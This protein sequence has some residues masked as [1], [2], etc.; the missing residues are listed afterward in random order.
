MADSSFATDVTAVSGLLDRLASGVNAVNTA[1]T[2]AVTAIGGGPAVTPS[3]TQDDASSSFM[4]LLGLGV[5]LYLV[6]G[7]KS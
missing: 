2:D 1:V 5:I 4:L 6:A 3:R 7:N